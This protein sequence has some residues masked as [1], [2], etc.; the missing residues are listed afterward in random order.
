M[1][2]KCIGSLVT[3]DSISLF[4]LRCRLTRKAVCARPLA[5]RPL[6]RSKFGKMSLSPFARSHPAFSMAAENPFLP[7][8]LSRNSIVTLVSLLS[9]TFISAQAHSLTSFP[10]TA[11]ASNLSWLAMMQ[12]S[13]LSGVFVSILTQEQRMGIAY[14]VTTYLTI[15]NL[16]MPHLR[17]CPHHWKPSRRM[18]RLFRIY[19]SAPGFP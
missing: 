3:F 2:V 10:I 15:L 5:P 12:I 4:L 16:A 19:E 14:T 13:G 17:R 7:A 9:E 18:C 1:L 6:C 11:S 8:S